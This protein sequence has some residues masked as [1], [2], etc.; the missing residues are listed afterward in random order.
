MRYNNAQLHFVCSYLGCCE[1]A[2]TIF[3]LDRNGNK[4]VVITLELHLEGLQEVHYYSNTAPASFARNQPK[5]TKLEA[6]FSLCNVDS[7]ASTI[8]YHQVPEFYVWSEAH[9]SWNRRKIGGQ[10]LL[11]PDGTTIIQSDTIGRLPMV[12]PKHGELYYLRI[13]LVNVKGPTSYTNIRTLASGNTLPTFKDAC[14]AR[15]LLDDDTHLQSA[16]TDLSQTSSASRLRDF[17]ITAVICCEPAH[18]NLLLDTFFEALSEDF[19]ME[20]RRVHADH[21]LGD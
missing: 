21:S 4:P 3:G 6:F 8:L 18:P 16:M 12:S 10:R 7:F 5:K 13:L 11:Q 15:G 19:I 14:V 1:G 20:R 9:R 2:T 17:F